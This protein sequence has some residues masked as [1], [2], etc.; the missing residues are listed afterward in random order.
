MVTRTGACVK[1][2]HTDEKTDNGMGADV[3]YPDIVGTRHRAG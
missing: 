3:P 2:Q 1:T